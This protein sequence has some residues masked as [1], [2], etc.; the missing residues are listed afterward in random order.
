MQI[1]AEKRVLE[2]SEGNIETTKA[3]F[4]VQTGET[5]EA[6]LRRVGLTGTSG[7][8][9]DQAEVRIKLVKAAG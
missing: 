4:V 8:H 2:M 5:V 9:Y 1:M 7:W 3:V 6:L